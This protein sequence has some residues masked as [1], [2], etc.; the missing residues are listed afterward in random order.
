MIRRRDLAAMLLLSSFAVHEG[1]LADSSVAFFASLGGVIGITSLATVALLFILL[2]RGWPA[3][4]PRAAATHARLRDGRLVLIREIGPAALDAL[5]SFFAALSPATRWLR[6]HGPMRAVPERLLREFT[7]VD[8]HEHV[9]FIAEAN[10]RAADGAPLLVAEARYVRCAG[11]DA[12]EFALVVADGWR[13][14]GLGSSLTR[15][16]LHRAR[17]AGVQ[18][19]CGEA[20]ADNEALRQFM[21]SLGAR[22]LGAIKSAATVR[23][24][25][26]TREELWP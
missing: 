22:P 2:R 12:A 20:L 3:A 18:H 17:L 11:S 19:L 24:C 1:F 13:R 23:L 8:Q 25:L 4:R 6:F 5:K 7:K 21:H 26:S 16:L 14:V 15:T 9:G 10:G